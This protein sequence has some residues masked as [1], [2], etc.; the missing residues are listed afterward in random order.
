MAPPLSQRLA[1]DLIYFEI[2]CD[3]YNQNYIKHSSMISTVTQILR[4][5]KFEIRMILNEPFQD[6]EIVI[7]GTCVVEAIKSDSPGL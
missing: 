4:N 6:Y 5:P 7:V 3:L 1:R 2:S